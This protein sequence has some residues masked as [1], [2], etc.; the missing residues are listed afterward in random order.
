MMKNLKRKPLILVLT[1]ALSLP[2]APSIAIG[3]A[4][5][6]EASTPIRVWIETDSR[7]LGDLGDNMQGA[8]IREVRSA[9]EAQGVVV[10]D[11]QQPDAAWLRIR[12]GGDADD[13]QLLEYTLYFELIDGKTA[14]QLIEPVACSECYDEN[15]YTEIARQA[16]VL[17]EAIEAVRAAKTNG[18]D[19]HPPPAGDGDGDVSDPPPV[20]LTPKAI[21]PLGFT[22]IGFTVAGLGAIVGGAV[23]LSRGNDY[24]QSEGYRRVTGTDHSPVGYVLTGVGAVATTA[25]LVMLGVDL[26]RRAKQRKQARPHVHIIPSISPAS[27]GVTFVGRF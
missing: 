21:G 4:P 27:A 15:F 8:V 14:T 19:E 22:G 24:E 2:L 3:Q 20:Q 17:V 9:F 11:T 18:S 26:G 10:L 13:V 25:G 16:P 1:V 7:A 23:E 12:I 6:P 5:Q